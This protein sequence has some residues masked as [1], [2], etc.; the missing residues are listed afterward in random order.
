MEAKLKEPSGALQSATGA[1]GP[2][3][4]PAEHPAVVLAVLCTAQFIGALD[5]FIVNVALP[6]IGVGVG[7]TRISLT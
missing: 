1:R 6:E 3:P 4:R 5:V 2:A 7:T